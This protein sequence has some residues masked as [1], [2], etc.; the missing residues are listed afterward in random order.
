MISTSL[1][2]KQKKVHKSLN[3]NVVTLRNSTTRSRDL[4]IFVWTMMLL[5]TT[6]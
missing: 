5:D 6:E 1:M 2:M 4:V 3:D